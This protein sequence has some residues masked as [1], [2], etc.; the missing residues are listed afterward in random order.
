MKSFSCLAAS[1]GFVIFSAASN[2]LQ[3]EGYKRKKEIR[4]SDLWE[5][6]SDLWENNF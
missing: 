4:M 6:I 5:N 2:N 1:S 3:A